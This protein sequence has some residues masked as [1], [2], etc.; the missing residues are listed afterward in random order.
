MRYLRTFC[1]IWDTRIGCI[2]IGYVSGAL[3][4]ACCVG[5]ILRLFLGLPLVLQNDDAQGEFPF[6]PLFFVFSAAFFAFHTIA[7]F[8]LIPAVKE[9]QGMFI[10]PIVVMLF[11]DILLDCIAITVLG[12]M[13]GR[14]NDIEEFLTAGVIISSILMPLLIYSVLIVISYFEEMFQQLDQV[15]L[16]KSKSQGKNE[17]TPSNSTGD[18]ATSFGTIV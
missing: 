17:T 13:L 8:S 1:C 18:S 6:N 4:V 7:S 11:I 14:Q 15:P 12:M 5:S 3:S 16:Q 10:V 2:V 9:G